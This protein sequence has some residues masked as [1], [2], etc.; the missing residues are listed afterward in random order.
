MSKTSMPFWK[1]PVL[2]GMMIAPVVIF[3]LSGG[4]GCRG[5]TKE[6]S[7]TIWGT[8]DCI[9]GAMS[10]GAEVCSVSWTS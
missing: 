5:W 3:R 7:V 10:A 4:A 9:G 2:V 6:V 1:P 8:S